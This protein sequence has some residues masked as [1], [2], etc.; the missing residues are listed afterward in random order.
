ML[1]CIAAAALLVGGLSTAS[2]EVVVL[3]DKATVIGKILAE[4]KDQ[5]VVDLGFTVLQIPR[6]QI[7]RVVKE[8]DREPK[9]PK[10]K[11]VVA[12]P[13]GAPPQTHEPADLYTA[14]KA[15][16]PEKSVR[17]LVAQLGEA[18]VQVRTPGGL[19]SGFFI[20]DEGYLITNFHVIEGETQIAVEVYHQ[21][22]GQLE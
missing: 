19:G 11:P 7:V 6:S 18:V 15:A 5:L 12:S 14:V 21:R 17:E 22:N 20:N 3:K 13:V 1:R 10:T 16:T 2:A 9:E 4:K 8:A